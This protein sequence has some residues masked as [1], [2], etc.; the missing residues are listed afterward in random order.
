[1][2]K[3]KIVTSKKRIEDANYYGDS[4]SYKLSV[5]N[6]GVLDYATDDIIDHLDQNLYVSAENMA[7][8]F[9]DDYGEYVSVTIRE[10]TIAEKLVEREEITFVNGAKGYKSNATNSLSNDYDNYQVKNDPNEIKSESRKGNTVVCQIDGKGNLKVSAGL[11]N[12]KVRKSGGSYSNKKELED[13]IRQSLDDVGF[14]LDANAKY[15][16]LWHNSKKFQFPGGSGKDF[17]LHCSV[18]NTYGLLGSDRPGRHAIKEFYLPNN[19]FFMGSGICNEDGG[20]LRVEYDHYLYQNI[21]NQ[22]KIIDIS[23]DLVEL[24]TVLDYEVGCLHRGNGKV[25]V[26]PAVTKLDGAVK[27]LIPIEGNSKDSQFNNLKTFDDKYYLL[28]KTGTYKNVNYNG[29]IIDEISFSEENERTIIKAY[30]PD[31]EGYGAETL[32]YKTVIDKSEGSCTGEYVYASWL[33]D[34]DS[35]RLNVSAKGTIL[36][37]KKKIVEKRGASPESD[38]LVDN[39]YKGIKSGDKITYRFALRNTANYPLILGGED[40]YDVLPETLG[41]WKWNNDNVKLEYVKED[42]SRIT[43]ANEEHYSITV[44]SDGQQKIVFAEDFEVKYSAASTLYVYVTLD[45]P[46]GKT[47]EDYDNSLQGVTISNT[48]YVYKMISKVYHD[49]ISPGKVAFQKGVLFT[50][51]GHSGVVNDNMRNVFAAGINGEY[52]IFDKRID[53]G[54]NNRTTNKATFYIT[55]VNSGNS[56]LPL[57]EIEDIL[58][59]GFLFQGVSVGNATNDFGKSGEIQCR[60]DVFGY[61]GDD[62]LGSSNWNGSVISKNGDKKAVKNLD[63]HIETEVGDFEPKGQKIKFS[64]SPNEGS[65]SSLEFDERTQKAYL[66][67]NQ[68]ITIV[69]QA[70]ITGPCHYENGELKYGTLAKTTNKA[71]MSFDDPYGLGVEIDDEIKV[72]GNINYIRPSKGGLD[73]TKMPLN[74][75]K[76]SILNNRVAENAGFSKDED[77]RKRLYSDVLL[78]RGEIKPGIS[79][80]VEK[81]VSLLGEELPYD[82]YADYTDTI[83]WKLTLSNE[84]DSNV[85]NFV[86]EDTVEYPHFFTGDVILRNQNSKYDKV[87]FSVGKM[88]RSLF[89]R[90]VPITIDNEKFMCVVGGAPVGRYDVQIKRTSTGDYLLRFELSKYMGINNANKYK[91]KINKE[92]SMEI[93]LNTKNML[94]DHRTHVYTNNANLRLPDYEFEN[95]QVIKGQ[96]L[97]DQVGKYINATAGVSVM[98][99]QQTTSEICVEEIYGTGDGMP[100]DDFFDLP[101]RVISSL[102]TP[103]YL[104]VRNQ[105]DELNYYLT[106][107]NN[108]DEN[109]NGMVLLTNFPE[110]GDNY[111]FSDSVSRNSQ[112]KVDIDMTRNVEVKGARGKPLSPEHYILEYSTKTEF[113]ENDWNGEPGGWTTEKIDGARS[114]R[115]IIKEDFTIDRNTPLEVVVPGRIASGYVPPGGY[116][117]CT[118]GYRYKTSV[119]GEPLEAGPG[120]VG[121]KMSEL[122]SVEKNLVSVDRPWIAEKDEICTFVVYE[123]VNW[124]PYDLPLESKED[125]EAMLISEGAKYAFYEIKVP[126]GES[127]IHKTLGERR[128]G[129]SIE[130]LK[131]HEDVAIPTNQSNFWI[132]D[133]NANYILLEVENSEDFKYSM[134]NGSHANYFEFEYDHVKPPTVKYVNELEKWAIDITKVSSRDSGKKLEGAVFGLYG[135]YS[136]KERVKKSDAEEKYGIKID[137]EINYDKESYP[138]RLLDVGATDENGKLSFADLKGEKYIIKE[139]KEPDGFVLNSDPIEV[140]VKDTGGVSAS[141]EL[142]LQNSRSLILPKTGGPGKFAFAALGLALIGVSI[143][144]AIKRIKQ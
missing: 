60:G 6:E 20:E 24:G 87:L 53:N 82:G 10:A 140:T 97:D 93:F 131:K 56:K 98:S 136:E 28:N 70:L 133:K 121:L 11:K 35:H 48:L 107:K 81:R 142:E 116:A 33:N 105:K 112:F 25:A 106:V 114:V 67:K 57:N 64:I 2:I 50:G 1:M 94:D 144:F 31:V 86:I 45:F 130:E 128:P 80:S 79:K 37:F 76:T 12:G 125:T 68:A 99:S 137:S 122:P 69:Y 52:D 72:E 43:L 117:W 88:E 58:P 61:R 119:D 110:E 83:M 29:K 124:Y 103:N 100:P 39:D 89:R 115:V 14:V 123:H 26:L 104:T 135:H 143:T 84:G 118:F 91:G 15:A 71:S 85:S 132:W 54:G 42:E 21:R 46:S 73:P 92:N 141:V 8:M 74:D 17:I 59:E 22:G 65:D 27:L 18:K 75:G 78:E 19:S 23:E 34:H 101:N 36:E 7:E 40:I 66:K 4:I 95:N 126:K 51:E 120:R 49:V 134:T 55:V 109:I 13:V 32:N 77:G 127:K 139:L 108:S 41:Y 16:V 111:T 129:D 30:F 113:D 44:P 102:E 5:H 63:Y 62:V 47:F 9:M 38:V 90:K 138:L 3:E 96:P